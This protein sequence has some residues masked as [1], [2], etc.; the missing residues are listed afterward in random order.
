[1]PLIIADIYAHSSKE[2]VTRPR[3][4]MDHLKRPPQKQGL[5]HEARRRLQIISLIKHAITLKQYF[6]KVNAVTIAFKHNGTQ[7]YREIIVGVNYKTSIVI[8]GGLMVPLD[9][10]INSLPSL[11]EASVAKNVTFISEEKF[12][13][14]PDIYKKAFTEPDYLEDY[15]R[16]HGRNYM[17][18]KKWVHE[19]YFP[20]TDIVTLAL[21]NSKNYLFEFFLAHFK[22]FYTVPISEIR[23]DLKHRKFDLNHSTS[24]ESVYT[25]EDSDVKRL[26]FAVYSFEGPELNP[27][28]LSIARFNEESDKPSLTITVTHKEDPSFASLIEETK[29]M[30]R[31][32]NNNNNPEKNVKAKCD[33]Q[34]QTEFG[35]QPPTLAAMLYCLKGKKLKALHPFKAEQGLS[36]QQ[37]INI[38][39]SGFKIDDFNANEHNTYTNSSLKCLCDER[40]NEMNWSTPEALEYAACNAVATYFVVSYVTPEVFVKTLSEEQLN[41][42]INAYFSDNALTTE[43]REKTPDIPAFPQLERDEPPPEFQAE[44]DPKESQQREEDVLIESVPGSS[45]SSWFSPHEYGNLDSPS[46]SDS[47]SLS[48]NAEH[49]ERTASVFPLA[50]SISPAELQRRNEI[51]DQETQIPTDYDSDATLS[52]DEDGGSSPDL[53]REEYEAQQNA[54]RQR[55]YIL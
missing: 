53:L 43:P 48:D 34:F 50:R 41:K 6:Y 23:V 33:G 37:A 28:L 54:K 13:N 39:N 30:Y 44:S 29:T 12:K 51:F 15:Q 46:E 55:H 8:S 32:E 20:D 49:V 4:T 19:N 7:L 22:K 35:I 52:P 47:S 26:K 25:Y 16:K 31:Y 2:L 38:L 10:F 17:T 42:N 45:E 14:A 27:T 21:N 11:F 5:K 9:T 18:F 36:Q 40:A 24:S 1:M 3:L